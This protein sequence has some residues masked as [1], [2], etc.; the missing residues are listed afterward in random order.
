MKSNILSIRRRTLDDDSASDRAEFV[1]S[2]INIPRKLR[3][4]SVVFDLTD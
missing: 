1:F 3:L 2:T 4:A